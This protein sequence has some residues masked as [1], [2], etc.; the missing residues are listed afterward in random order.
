MVKD[1]ALREVILGGDAVQNYAGHEILYLD[2]LEAKREGL[3]LVCVV[4]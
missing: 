4:L 1:C 2:G 3:C